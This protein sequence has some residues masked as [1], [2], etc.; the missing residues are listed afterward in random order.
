[1]QFLYISTMYPKQDFILFYFILFYFCGQV[2]DQKSISC[3]ASMDLC[4]APSKLQKKQ[5]KLFLKSN[6]IQKKTKRNG[7]MTKRRDTV[8][9]IWRNKSRPSRC[10]CCL[11]K[12]IQKKSKSIQP[13]GGLGFHPGAQSRE[14]GRKSACEFGTMELPSWSMKSGPYHFQVIELW[15]GKKA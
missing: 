13:A 4:S 1:M 10:K 12:R 7:K 9:K 15:Q 5:H 14:M 6:Q 2:L 11:Q 8:L 3:M